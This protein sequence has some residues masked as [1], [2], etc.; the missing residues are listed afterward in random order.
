MSSMP[1]ERQQDFRLLI[2]TEPFDPREADTRGRRQVTTELSGG[3]QT[4]RQAMIVQFAAALTKPDAV[5]LQAAYGLKLDR[6]IPNLAYLERLPAE[7]VGELRGDFLVRACI[8]L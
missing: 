1:G 4:A 7:T 8:A 6:Y 2:G 5:R 3:R